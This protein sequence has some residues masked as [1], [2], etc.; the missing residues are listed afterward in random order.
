MNVDIKIDTAVRVFECRDWT[1]GKKAT[2]R[3]QAET[4]Q[5]SLRHEQDH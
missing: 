3:E 4:S 2:L 1:E 5:S